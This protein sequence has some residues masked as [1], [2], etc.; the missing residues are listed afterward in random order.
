MNKQN[1]QLTALFDGACPICRRKMHWTQ[2]RDKNHT[3]KVVDIS[4]KGFDSSC[5]GIDSKEAMEEMHVIRSDGSVIRG[6]DAVV[7]LYR[8]VGLGWLIFPATLPG[9]RWLFRVAYRLFAK[10]RHWFFSSP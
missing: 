8:A 9:I 5:Y 10:H 7:C 2:K 1:P 3:I 4:S 6:F